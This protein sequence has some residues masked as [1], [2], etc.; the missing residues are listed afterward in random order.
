VITASVLAD[1]RGEST[2]RLTTF[3]VTMPKWILA[4][5]NTHRAV[6]KNVSSSRAIPVARLMA[7]IKDAPFVPAAFGANQRGMQ[8]SDALDAE[9]QEAAKAAWMSSHA[10]AIEAVTKLSELNVHKQWANRLIE[11][12]M[13]AT[14]VATASEY[15]WANFFGLRCSPLAQPEMKE[16]ACKM[17]KAYVD[18]T[19]VVLKPNDWHLPYV[20][21]AERDAYGIDDLLK[22][23]SARCARTSYLP[24]DGSPIDL[25]KDRALHDRLR[26]D[27]HMSP[28]EHQAQLIGEFSLAKPGN[29]HGQWT[30]YRKMLAGEAYL[31]IPDEAYAIAGIDPSKHGSN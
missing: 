11:P 27:H 18:S 19:A 20:T 14:A 24:P 6:S 5:F 26:D 22:F 9:K 29:L 16:L 15:G 12:F 13:Y 8:A 31:R 23:S 17:L 4:E 30:Q 25:D 3:V 2:C 21:S 28:F 10:A 7:Q 1:S